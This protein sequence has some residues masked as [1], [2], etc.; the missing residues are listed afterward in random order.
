MKSSSDTEEMA[1]DE[2]IFRFNRLLKQKQ[3]EQPNV[4]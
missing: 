1:Y 3:D 4:R 2:F